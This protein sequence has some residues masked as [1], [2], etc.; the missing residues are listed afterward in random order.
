VEIYALDLLRCEGNQIDIR[1]HCST[2]TYLRSIAHDLG[3]AL[4][5][6]AFL[7]SL[8]PGQFRRLRFD[9]GSYAGPARGDCGRG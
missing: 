5:T 4:G 8:R 6:G 9:N 3:V 7:R 2:G 1:V